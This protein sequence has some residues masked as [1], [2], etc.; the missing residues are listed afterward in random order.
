MWGVVGPYLPY[1]AHIDV[2]EVEVTDKYLIPS[3]LI[4]TLPLPLPAARHEGIL[5]SLRRHLIAALSCLFITVSSSSYSLLLVIYIGLGSLEVV[6][7][8]ATTSALSVQCYTAA[9]QVDRHQYRCHQ[10]LS[11]H[12]ASTDMARLRFSA[13][14][15]CSTC[16]GVDKDE[17]LHHIQRPLPARSSAI[18]CL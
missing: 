12:D 5:S 9:S 8:P 14:V 10:L 13:T 6:C 18:Q 3:F 2:I 11:R 4:V 17:L 1:L 15:M 7:L 16:S